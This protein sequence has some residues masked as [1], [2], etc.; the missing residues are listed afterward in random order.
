MNLTLERDLLLV[1]NRI[2]ALHAI[3]LLEAIP[4]KL[5]YKTTCVACTRQTPCLGAA[6]G[7]YYFRNK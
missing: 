2:D 7:R 5:A 3:G 4:Y 1:R 6:G